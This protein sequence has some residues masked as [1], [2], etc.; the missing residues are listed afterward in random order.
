MI[1]EEFINKLNAMIAEN[2]SLKNA[3]VQVEHQGPGGCETCGYGG[4]TTTD[5]EGSSI[6]DLETKLV[7]SVV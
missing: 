6:Y 3:V 1:V 7:I 2:P 4:E 5:V